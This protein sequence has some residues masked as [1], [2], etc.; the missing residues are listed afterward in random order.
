MK[1]NLGVILKGEGFSEMGRVNW[2]RKVG[3]D[4]LR[5][6]FVGMSKKMMPLSLGRRCPCI[7]RKW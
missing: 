1:E 6:V 3:G 5:V 2:V 7:Y 4:S